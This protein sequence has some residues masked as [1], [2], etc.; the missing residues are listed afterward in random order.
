VLDELPRETLEALAKAAREAAPGKLGEAAQSLPDE[1]KDEVAEATKAENAEAAKKDDDGQGI[2]PE[3]L[4]KMADLVPPELIA[5][6]LSMRSQG[7]SADTKTPPISPEDAREVLER[8]SPKTLEKLAKAVM[9]SGMR[10]PPPAEGAGQPAG[11]PAGSA[12]SPAPRGSPGAPPGSSGAPRAS[13]G[14]GDAPAF[15]PEAAQAIARG[16]S[17][18]TLGE[19]QKAAQ[20]GPASSAGRAR[21]PGGGTANTNRKGVLGRQS[22]EPSP[23]EDAA[24]RNPAAAPRVGSKDGPPAPPDPDEKVVKS[25]PRVEWSS[26]PDQLPSRERSALRAELSRERVPASYE[27]TVREYFDLGKP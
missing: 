25:A 27:K 2:P 12:E 17:P 18:E 15:S 5:K 9:E 14:A 6:A 10:G 7:E 26:A 22:D 21:M 11:E 13:P 16:L 19:I 3:A 23:D 8:L 24:E 4:A 1:V 20:A